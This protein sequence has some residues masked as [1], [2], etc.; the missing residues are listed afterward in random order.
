MLNRRVGEGGTYGD[1]GSW[2]GAGC[3]VRR[4]DSQEQ[5]G[6]VSKWAM[7]PAFLPSCLL[8]PSPEGTQVSLGRPSG[9]SQSQGV[10]GV[11]FHPNPLVSQ[12]LCASLAS[13]TPSCW[14]L[15]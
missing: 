5:T 10:G 4:L 14:K 1:K 8:A 3:R 7:P 6:I 12:C 9:S 2:T 15:F 13:V 11:A